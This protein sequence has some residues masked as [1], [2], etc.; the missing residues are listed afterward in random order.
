MLRPSIGIIFNSSRERGQE[1]DAAVLFFV[2][3]R[4]HHRT[5]SNSSRWPMTIPF[6]YYYP[7]ECPESNTNKDSNWREKSM[8]TTKT[9]TKGGK[10]KWKEWHITIG[11]ES[12]NT[13]IH[14]EGEK[15]ELLFIFVLCPIRYCQY[16]VP[17]NRQQLHQQQYQLR[18]KRNVQ[19]Y[20]YHLHGSR[21]TIHYS[22]NPTYNT[23]CDIIMNG[24]YTVI[25][26]P[27]HPYQ[28][29]TII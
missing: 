14:K 24:R 19:W 25:R 12:P 26:V 20:Y 27:S 18:K 9:W 6:Y 11:T 2:S 10:E 8:G 16:A 23:D 4:T 13:G 22:S 7:D 17:I 28:H 3:Y 21:R 29:G 15:G 5:I 1:E